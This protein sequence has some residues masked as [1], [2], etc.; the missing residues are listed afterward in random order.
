MLTLRTTD[1]YEPSQ[2][3]DTPDYS[4]Q[5][6]IID[7]TTDFTNYYTFDNTFY[8]AI[9][10]KYFVENEINNNF[11]FFTTTLTVSPHKDAKEIMKIGKKLEKKYGVTF[12]DKDFKKKD[13]FKKASALSKELD[14]YRQDYCGCEFSKIE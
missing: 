4:F 6:A 13:G 9:D 10:D 11:D 3:D 8:N 2:F 14:L 5:S 1:I 12:L 7:D